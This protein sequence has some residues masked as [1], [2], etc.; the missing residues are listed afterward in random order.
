[1]TGKPINI[2]KFFQSTQLPEKHTFLKLCLRGS[3]TM[4]Q[5]GISFAKLVYDS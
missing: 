2:S 4:G 1:M 5:K 3:E